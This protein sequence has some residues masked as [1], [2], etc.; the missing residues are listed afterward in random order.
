MS[1]STEEYVPTLQWIRGAK[2]MFHPRR[3]SIMN[4]KTST[5]PS[6]MSHRVFR[7]TLQSARLNFCNWLQQDGILTDTMGD[8]H[9]QR[10]KEMQEDW[11]EVSDRPLCVEHEAMACYWW[12]KHWH[13]DD[14]HDELFKLWIACEGPLFALEA[15]MQA[16]TLMKELY[17]DED[18]VMEHSGGKIEPGLK[19]IRK[20]LAYIPEEHYKAAVERAEALWPT[21]D[22]LYWKAAFAY[23]FPEKQVW[24]DEAIEECVSSGREQGRLFLL[25]SGASLSSWQ[26]LMKKYPNVSPH[27]ASYLACALEY[28]GVEIWREL[29]ELAYNIPSWEEEKERLLKVLAVI[30]H[31]EV[32]EFFVF[33]MDDESKPLKVSSDYVRRSLDISRPFLQEAVDDYDITERPL[34]HELWSMLPS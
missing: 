27:N 7:E 26:S 11:Q 10:A 23:M 32:A 3:G 31:P 34:A 6:H 24:G 25:A 29:L 20:A 4:P 28:H 16:Q 17:P 30:K 13:R 9:K 12:V 8:V 22:G 21:L 33:R 1:E 19:L 15:L 18:S 5:T 14:A 2:R